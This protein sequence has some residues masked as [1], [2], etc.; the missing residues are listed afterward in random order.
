VLLAGYT[1]AVATY[2]ATKMITCSPMIGQLCDTMIA[3]S[4]DKE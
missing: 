2:F 3:A 1:A 4:S